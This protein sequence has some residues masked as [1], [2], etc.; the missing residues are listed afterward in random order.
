[1]A[2]KKKTDYSALIATADTGTSMAESKPLRHMK[3]Q[4]FP[5]GGKSHFSLSFFDHEMKTAGLKPEEGLMTII[6]CDLEG[7]RD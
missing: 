1:M 6:D 3:L 2:K 7:Q 5:G 4:A